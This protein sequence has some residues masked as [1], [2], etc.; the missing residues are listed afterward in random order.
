MALTLAPAS[1]VTPLVS[2]TPIFGLVLAYIFN[3]KL[4]IFSRPVI[5]GTLMVFMGTVLLI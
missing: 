3:R 1:V 2:I 4:E 5:I